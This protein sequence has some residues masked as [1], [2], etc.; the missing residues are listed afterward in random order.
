MSCRLRPASFAGT[1]MFSL[2]E[3]CNC[4][5]SSTVIPWD[6]TFVNDAGALSS[7]VEGPV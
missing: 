1:V 3:L 5:S 7:G 4:S 6:M 2:S